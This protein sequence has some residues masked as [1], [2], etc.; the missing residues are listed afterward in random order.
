MYVSLSLIIPNSVEGHVL[1]RARTIS[2]HKPRARRCWINCKNNQSISVSSAISKRYLEPGILNSH[3]QGQLWASLALTAV[4][5]KRM[6][7]DELNSAFVVILDNWRFV[8]AVVVKGVSSCSRFHGICSGRIKAV[9]FAVTLRNFP[10]ISRK[11]WRGMTGNIKSG[12]FERWSSTATA[13]ATAT[14]T[15]AWDLWHSPVKR[16]SSISRRETFLYR[17]QYI[18]EAFASKC[19]CSGCL[20]P[21]VAIILPKWSRT[22]KVHSI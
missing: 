4:Y 10:R 6:Q 7:I 15:T 17:R 22:K 8:S 9:C 2:R 12:I 14:T 3:D 21:G 13:T 5:L 11:R 19:L 18:P 1:L 20:N 16:I